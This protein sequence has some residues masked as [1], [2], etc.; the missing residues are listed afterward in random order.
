VT[1]TYYLPSAQAD[2]QLNLFGQCYEARQQ[3][4]MV[5]YNIPGCVGTEIAVSTMCEAARRGWIRY[6]KESSGNMYY[7]KSLVLTGT[8]VGL[9]V[10]QGDEGCM[11][12]GLLAG[13]CGIVPVC[14]N[15]EPETYLRTYQAAMKKDLSELEKLDR[16]ILYV[17]QKV[18]HSG[19]FWLSGIKYCMSKKGLASDKVISPLLSTS[20][21]QKDIIDNEV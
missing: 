21:E 20:K 3:M 16:R 18:V 17:K 11:V 19:P 12:Q 9:Q 7:F 13:A 8:E 10:L 14:A 2:S 4:Q 5:L 1:P 15:F 6:C